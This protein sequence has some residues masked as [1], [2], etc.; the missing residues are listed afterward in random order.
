MEKKPSRATERNFREC[1]N[2]LQCSIKS[3]SEVTIERC[4]NVSRKTCKFLG[5]DVN[6]QHRQH[7]ESDLKVASRS[8][9]WLP[10]TEVTMYIKSVLA[11]SKASLRLL[12]TFVAGS[13]QERLGT[14][15]GKMLPHRIE[16]IAEVACESFYSI[17]SQALWRLLEK[18]VT[19]QHRKHCG[20]NLRKIL[21]HSIE[22]TRGRWFK[23]A[24]KGS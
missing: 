7:R 24:S 11:V 16:S 15:L 17:A 1:R 9:W 6:T 18:D 22:C 21:Q 13:H 4:Y 5:Q 3:I 19:T 2:M 20:G 14:Y 10:V 12:K 23:A 8:S